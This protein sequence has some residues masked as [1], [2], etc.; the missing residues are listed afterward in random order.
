M[1]IRGHREQVVNI[2]QEILAQPNARYAAQR[3]LYEIRATL[4]TK[5]K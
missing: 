4:L 3:K 5:R 2:L 1:N